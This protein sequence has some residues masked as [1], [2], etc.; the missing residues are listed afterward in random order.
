MRWEGVCVWVGVRVGVLAPSTINHQPQCGHQAQRKV[1]AGDNGARAQQCLRVWGRP[2]YG[3]GRAAWAAHPPALR[4][5]CLASQAG[6]GEAVYASAR[7]LMCPAVPALDAPRRPRRARCCCC[8]SSCPT[9]WRGCSR[10]GRRAP[11]T[12]C[13]R[14]CP[15][16]WGG[17]G[18]G[19]EGWEGREN[20]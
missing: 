9:R 7:A 5:Q 3:C 20:A 15:T 18:R 4:T 19:G 17:R 13:L 2:G 10:P 1:G 8:C 11:C 6:W 14:P 12:A 16:R